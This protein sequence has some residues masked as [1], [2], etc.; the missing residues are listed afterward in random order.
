VYAVLQCQPEGQELPDGVAPDG[1]FNDHEWGTLVKFNS[2]FDVFPVGRIAGSWDGAVPEKV[3][4]RY[5]NT[6]GSYGFGRG[7]PVAIESMH[8]DY[9]GASPITMCGCTCLNSHF[10]LDGFERAFLPAAQTCTVNVLDSN[11]NLILRIGGYGNCDSRGTLSSVTDPTTGAL[12]PRR[13]GDPPD[14]ANPLAKPEIAFAFPRFT[15]VTDEAL[16]V[17]DMENGRIVRA[18]IGYH[19]EKTVPLP[20]AP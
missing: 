19:S 1:R 11:G 8:W 2:R 3:T 12:R 6:G 5:G 15:A 17:H 9:G 18:T 13:P 10:D 16:Y 14:L 7:V 20:P 4:H